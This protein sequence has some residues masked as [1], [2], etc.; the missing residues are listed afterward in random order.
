MIYFCLCVRLCWVGLI[1]H[2]GFS[3][4]IRAAEGILSHILTP[5]FLLPVSPA[6]GAV[7]LE[8]PT[9]PSEPPFRR[10]RTQTS[11]SGPSAPPLSSLTSAWREASP[12][13]PFSPHALCRRVAV[14][15]PCS[16][17][18]VWRREGFCWPRRWAGFPFRADDPP[19]QKQ[20]ARRDV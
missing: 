18:Q 4:F 15:C 12:R 6:A 17:C 14:A 3:T 5:I 2:Q 20:G 19:P 11:L 16:S 1:K 9:T 8:S 13:S 7:R 10:S